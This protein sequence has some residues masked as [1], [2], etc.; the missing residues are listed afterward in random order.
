MID[1]E[2]EQEK[3]KVK[4]EKYVWKCICSL[5]TSR[6]NSECYI[7]RIF[8]IKETQGKGSKILTPKQI[9][10]RKLQR[11]PMSYCTSKSR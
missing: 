4:K 11:L 10:T 7:S 1:L 2:H 3:V 6:I 8:P 5:W 9:L